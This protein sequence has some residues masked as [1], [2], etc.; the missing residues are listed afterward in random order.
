MWHT[1]V[2]IINKI[3][4]LV[5]PE[6]KA[7]RYRSKLENLKLTKKILLSKEPTLSSSRRLE[8]IEKQIKEIEVYL[9][10]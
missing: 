6:Q 5:S 4:D 9:R 10:S 3:M 2:E 1:V 7:K 8:K